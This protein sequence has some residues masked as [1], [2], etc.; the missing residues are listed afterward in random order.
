[1]CQVICQL[2]GTV[3]VGWRVEVLTGTPRRGRWSMAEKAAIVVESQAPGAQAS[4]IALRYG[5]HRNQ[6]YGWRREFG[7]AADANAMA[8][9][10]ARE[11][12]FVPVVADGGSGAAP[13]EIEIGRATV[14][15]SGWGRSGGPWQGATPV[16]GDEVIPAL[17]GAP[18]AGVRV[19]IATRPVDFRRGGFSVR[20]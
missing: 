20:F 16:E 19:L 15:V 9:A 14:R 2:M 11:L 5:L 13:I 8:E 10:G 3:S 6:L 4:E 12:D 17:S 7:A 1:M 18:P